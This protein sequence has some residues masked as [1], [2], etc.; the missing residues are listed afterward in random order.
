MNI[1][2]TIDE[3]NENQRIFVLNTFQ[4]IKLTPSLKLLYGK[5]T[6]LE[7]HLD[8]KHAFKISHMM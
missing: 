3:I 8:T 7:N 5:L 1:H 6:D 2:F 4:V